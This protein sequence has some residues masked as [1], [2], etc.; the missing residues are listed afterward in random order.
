MLKPTVCKRCD[1]KNSPDSKFCS[2]CSFPLD[3][4]TVIRMDETRAKLDKLLDKLTE[5]PKRLSRLIELIESTS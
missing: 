4:E 2:K 1:A 3:Y 5:D